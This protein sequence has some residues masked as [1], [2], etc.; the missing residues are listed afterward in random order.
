MRPGPVA[1]DIEDR[2]EPKKHNHGRMYRCKIVPFAGATEYG[3]WLGTESEVR[4]A[5]SNRVR[6]LGTRYYCEM[7][8]IT[9]PECNINEGAKVIS[10]L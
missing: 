3:E 5:M 10:A 1:P 2:P 4:A 7:K 6:R 8:T 9:C